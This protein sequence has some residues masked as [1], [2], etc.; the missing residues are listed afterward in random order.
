MFLGYIYGLFDLVLAC[1]LLLLLLL[2]LL[3]LCVGV[4]VG[5]VGDKIKACAMERNKVI[6]YM[7]L[8]ANLI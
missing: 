4:G 2:L 8:R 6:I 3:F 7:V 5:L 1:F